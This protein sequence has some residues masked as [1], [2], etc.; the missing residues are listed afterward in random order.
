MI[1]GVKPVLPSTHPIHATLTCLLLF[2]LSPLPNIEKW[3]VK[4]FTF[5]FMISVPVIGERQ[6]ML[7]GEM[8]CLNGIKVCGGNMT[9]NTQPLN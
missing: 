1:D 9:P 5:S 8:K 6:L 4:R 2:I 7:T 3:R